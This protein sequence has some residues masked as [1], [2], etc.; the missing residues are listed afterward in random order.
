[1]DQVKNISF[2]IFARDEDEA[3]NGEQAIKDFIALMCSKGVKVTGDKIAEAVKRLNKNTF[4]LN[5]IVKFFA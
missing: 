1:M 2:N 5:E 4:I 3:R